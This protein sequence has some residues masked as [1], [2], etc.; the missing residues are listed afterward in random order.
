MAY[1]KREAS[2]EHAREKTGAIFDFWKS[3]LLVAT[4]MLFSDIWP[5][6]VKHFIAET[7][8]Y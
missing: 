3:T 7:E 5:S 8:I 2:S 4:S 1:I 6:F